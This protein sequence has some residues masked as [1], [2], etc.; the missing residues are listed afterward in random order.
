[1]IIFGTRDVGPLKYLLALENQLENVSWMSSKR[2]MP[3]LSNKQK[4]S[5]IKNKPFS[6]FSENKLI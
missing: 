1:M 6:L 5:R 2:T 3:Y 4:L